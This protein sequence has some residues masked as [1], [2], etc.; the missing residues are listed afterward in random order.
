MLCREKCDSEVG[1]TTPSCLC[2]QP[3]M[4]PK[5]RK[6]ANVKVERAATFLEASTYHVAC[7]GWW[8]LR[9]PEGSMWCSCTVMTPEGWGVTFPLEPDLLLP[10]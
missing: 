9:L 5:G 6:L 7:L 8:R 10:I 1:Y 2:A 4:G 3:R